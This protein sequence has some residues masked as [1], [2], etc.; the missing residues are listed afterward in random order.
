[1]DK[2]REQIHLIVDGFNV[3]HAWGL[4]KRRSG[5]WINQIVNALQKELREIH[6]ER[7]WRVTIVLDGKGKEIDR[8]HPFGDS[9]FRI[10]FSPSSMTADAVIEQ[11]VS[12][13]EQSTEI[14]VATED[15]AVLHSVEAGGAETLSATALRE[16][17]GAA[18]RMNRSRMKNA[19]NGAKNAF[20]NR[21]PL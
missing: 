14:R 10:L 20:E 2:A 9:S 15:R 4:V 7:G 8:Q 3:A 16:E 18:R 1:M 5:D 11:M 17:I 12:G 19:S 13:E 21:I 6:D